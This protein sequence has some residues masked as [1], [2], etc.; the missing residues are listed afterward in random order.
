MSRW[1]HMAPV[2]QWR[3]LSQAL[4]PSQTFWWTRMEPI[5][6]FQFSTLICDTHFGL[7]W[8]K[9]LWSVRQQNLQNTPTPQPSPLKRSSKEVVRVHCMWVHA[10][11]THSPNA[12]TRKTLRH[13]KSSLIISFSLGLVIKVW[14]D[15]NFL[16]KI[17]VIK[18][19]KIS[20]VWL[21]LVWIGHKRASSVDIS[22]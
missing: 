8:D 5:R 11:D 7:I 13:T 22:Y 18:V 4:P 6:W 16:K 3:M 15:V 19:L 9:F 12:T 21:E 1:L 10:T 17:N 2:R 20:R 14:V